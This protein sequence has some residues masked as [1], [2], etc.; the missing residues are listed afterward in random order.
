MNW[1]ADPVTREMLPAD[2]RELR[3]LRK[4]A[5]ERQA[6]RHWREG[7]ISGFDYENGIPVRM[8]FAEC[9][10]ECCKR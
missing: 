1:L 8:W 2:D 4:V 10:D 9:P 7:W 3:L 5:R 6:A